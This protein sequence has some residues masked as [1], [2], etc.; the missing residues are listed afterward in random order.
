MLCVETHNSKFCGQRRHNNLERA[1]YGGSPSSPFIIFMDI[2][3]VNENNTVKWSIL[4]GT[5]VSS[6]ELVPP[7]P[8]FHFSIM[9]RLA[10][11]GVLFQ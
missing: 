11:S 5:K 8:N 7:K 3:P 9:K 10:L 4:K 2:E 6:W 1:D